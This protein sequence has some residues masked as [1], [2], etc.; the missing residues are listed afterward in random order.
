MLNTLDFDFACGMT[1]KHYLLV[2]SVDED[3]HADEIAGRGG[4]SRTCVQDQSV[5][6]WYFE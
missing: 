5:S 3:K 4:I 6:C 2:I 1:A